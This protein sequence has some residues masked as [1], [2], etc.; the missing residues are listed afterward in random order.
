M[1]KK[2]LSVVFLILWLLGATGCFPIVE[3][4]VMEIG[5]DIMKDFYEKV[6][7]SEREQYL[8]K[9]EK[10]I[11]YA[12]IDET[13]FLVYCKEISHSQ[14]YIWID[15]FSY[16][17]K[18]SSTFNVKSACLKSND[19]E[20]VCKNDKLQITIQRTALDRDLNDSNLILCYD[21]SEEWYYEGNELTLSVEIEVENK[22]V[23][24]F[25]PVE[26][27]GYIRHIFPT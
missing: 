17:L 16:D 20:V 19:G 5:G 11:K 13:F 25:Y 26:I 10:E 7:P 21:I 4:P 18:N 6:L 14:G 1:L 22:T 15:A 9:H 24:L 8:R 3:S 23:M 27:C 12:V 2:V